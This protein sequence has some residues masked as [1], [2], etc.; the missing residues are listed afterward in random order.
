MI[1]LN[2]IQKEAYKL[3][4]SDARFLYALI[5]LRERLDSNYVLMAMPY[6]G[7]FADG[8]E[9]WGRKVGI[10]T[11]VFNDQ[12]KQYY[13]MIRSKH[14]LFELSYSELY[15][16]LYYEFKKSDEHFSSICEPIEKE[17]NLYYNVGVDVSRNHYCGN[18]ILCST[19]IPF[20]DFQKDTGEFMK[21]ISVVAG[22]LCAFYDGHLP[23]A[24]L[25]KD[26]I[27]FKYQ[28]HHFF[29]HCPLKRNDFDGF[30]LFSILC[31]INYLRLFIDDFF[32]EEYPFKL[33]FA[34][35]QYYYLVCLMREINTKLATEF[36]IDD[37][38]MNNNFR[39]CMAHYGLGVEMTED[40]IIVGDP[41]SGLT[42]KLFKTSYMQTKNA[43]YTELETLS[44]Q[45]EDCL[46]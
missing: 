19:H 4:Q 10:D 34:Y 30:V 31:N 13:A 23:P 8:S 32:I 21:N 40:D 12:E 37:K 6:T 14:K 28:D 42:N 43:I 9:Q 22:R 29:A 16:T 7:I 25:F 11:P 26:E 41:M 46:L 5:E 17:R 45:L 3:I 20:Y 1:E 36:V 18:T 15:S 35:L 2:E 24:P 27:E 39:N 33:R 38:W 44:K